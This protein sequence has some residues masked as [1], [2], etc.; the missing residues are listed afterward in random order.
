[1]VCAAP[2]P[3]SSNQALDDLGAAVAERWLALLCGGVGGRVLSVEVQLEV[4][5][6]DA[7]G[8]A[9]QLDVASPLD[10]HRAIAE[11]LDGAHVVRDEEHR[12]ALVAHAVE[13][14][15]ALLLE[16]G[17]ADGEHLVDQQ[18]VGVHLDRHRER[19]PDLHAGRVVLELEVDELLEL[20]ELDDLVEALARL[21]AG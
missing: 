4:L 17:V 5:A 8:L 6:A 3:P 1:M 19:E 14:V 12:L 16:G 11:A 2:R 10:Q 20:G 9:D 7:L 21:R 13:L 18:D 15:E